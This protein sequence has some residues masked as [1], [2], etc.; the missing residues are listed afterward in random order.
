[1]KEINK[2]I[3]IKQYLLAIIAN[4]P[5]GMLVI[6]FR[7][8]ISIINSA[9]QTFLDLS[10]GINKY[11][12]RN[13]LSVVEGMPEFDS[14]ITLCMRRRKAFDIDNVQYNNKYFQING[15]IVPNGMLITIEDITILK[16]IEND[17]LEKTRL[18]KS[19]NKELEQF[20]HIAS[21]DLQEPLSTII[22]FSN[23][24]IKDKEFD[25]ENFKKFLSYI[26]KS[27]N[28]MSIQIKSL[29]E[30][31]R[32]G[33]S[34][35]KEYTDCNLLVKNIIQSLSNSI[36]NSR[37]EIEVEDLPNLTLFK[38]EFQSIFQNLISNA[39][40]YVPKG[41]TPKI[42]IWAIKEKQ[43]CKFAIQDNGIGV[44]K[45]NY[46]KIFIVFKRLHRQTEYPGTGIGLAHCQKVVDMHKGN[47]WLES[48]PGA[49][50]TFY[51]TI[52]IESDE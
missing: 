9:A 47:I 48:E 5:F 24:L 34:K 15:R 50:T 49:G 41:R 21:H 17:L 19:S 27:A 40:K 3:E 46:Q 39:I 45:D 16:N 23:I 29:L 20:A 31:S 44:S 18:L 33:Q 10:D 14:Q 25:S 35:S 22:G 26:S 28:R 32:I 36:E 13:I 12:N 6:D 52:N 4:S 42:K 2:N 51:F 1:M 11:L 8:N 43:H 7:G 37:A 30:Y 38:M